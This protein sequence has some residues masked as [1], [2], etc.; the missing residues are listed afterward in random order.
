MNIF[1]SFIL[2]ASKS[3]IKIGVKS[4]TYE[5]IELATNKFNSSTQVGRGYGKVYKGLLA[6]G[7][8][9]AIK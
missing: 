8:A 4:F 2:T 3:P 6:D 7:I 9:V 1:L 5:E